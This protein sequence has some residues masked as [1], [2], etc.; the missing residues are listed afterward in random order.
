M[1]LSLHQSDYLLADVEIQFRRYLEKVDVEVARRY[2]AAGQATLR[3]VLV[4]P[5]QGRRRGA[6]DPDLKRPALLSGGEAI[7]QAAFVLPCRG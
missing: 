1:P 6:K 5:E 2:R 7:S 4:R 3:K